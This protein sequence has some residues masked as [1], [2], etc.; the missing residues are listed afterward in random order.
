MVVGDSPSPGLQVSALLPGWS[1]YEPGVTCAICGKGAGYLVEI[2][3]APPVH[4][5]CLDP[6]VPRRRKGAGN[7]GPRLFDP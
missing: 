4:L 5:K 1:L 3:G 2:R 6:P 7:P